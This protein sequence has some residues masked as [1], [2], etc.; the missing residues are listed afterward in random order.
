[1]HLAAIRET[2]PCN[3]RAAT[4]T[5]TNIERGYAQCRWPPF[6]PGELHVL[7]AWMKLFKWKAVCNYRAN[8]YVPQPQIRARA[9]LARLESTNFI[10]DSSLIACGLAA[11]APLNDFLIRRAPW[12]HS[13]NLKLVFARHSY[14]KDRLDSTHGFAT[15]SQWFSN[16]Y[17]STIVL[18]GI[19]YPRGVPRDQDFSPSFLSFYGT[20]MGADSLPV[21]NFKVSSFVQ[22]LRLIGHLKYLYSIKTIVVAGTRSLKFHL[23]KSA[24]REEEILMGIFTA[25][26]VGIC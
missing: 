12:D 8:M 11:R 15:C 7:A 3:L 14:V 18:G 22:F 1:V 24:G 17:L 26:S 20:R 16:S 5:E 9:S 10:V 25:M 2:H 13:E 21:C 19:G 23:S 4:I 6:V